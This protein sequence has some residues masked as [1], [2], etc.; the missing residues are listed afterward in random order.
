MTNTLKLSIVASLA[1]SA[2]S[3]Q[4]FTGIVFNV[5]AHKG[6]ETGGVRELRNNDSRFFRITNQVASPYNLD[7]SCSFYGLQN[8]TNVSHLEISVI[9]SR[10]K[11]SPIKMYLYDYI[12][13]RW[14]DVA[15]V[16]LPN[17]GS[18]EFVLRIRKAPERFV[19]PNG[20][21]TM[22]F[23]STLQTMIIDQVTFRA[24]SER[25]R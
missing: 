9:G 8:P 18:D 11:S 19:S 2:F 3:A 7:W 5:E 6:K 4:A 25:R 23:I 14:T 22:R 21:A 16:E 20:R 24:V 17:I 12:A 13:L 1:L 15:S 10:L